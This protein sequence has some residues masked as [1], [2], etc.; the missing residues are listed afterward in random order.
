MSYKK[1]QYMEIIRRVFEE[2][3]E[4][5]KADAQAGIHLKAQRITKNFEES[6]GL[7]I[8]EELEQTG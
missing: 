4:L 3:Y 5:G 8:I 6:R 7:E 2:G 1:N